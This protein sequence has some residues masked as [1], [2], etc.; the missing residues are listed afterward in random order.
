MAPG[1]PG[2][3]KAIGRFANPDSKFVVTR[4]GPPHTLESSTDS[5]HGPL[6]ILH[7]I[8]SDLRQKLWMEPILLQLGLF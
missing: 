8:S 6:L 2:R 3:S 7:I 1:D 5:V 4:V